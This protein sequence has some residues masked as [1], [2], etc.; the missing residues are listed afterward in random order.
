VAKTPTAM[1]SPIALSASKD[2]L[3]KYLFHNG[4]GE[5]EMLR[6]EELKEV[7]DQFQ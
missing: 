6:G 1:N 7:M 2:F 3:K 5:K 4:E